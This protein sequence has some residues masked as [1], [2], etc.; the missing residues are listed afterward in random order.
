MNPGE[1]QDWEARKT[2]NAA[3]VP[4]GWKMSR[5][6]VISRTKQEAEFLQGHL[7]L[8]PVFFF[9]KDLFSFI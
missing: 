1:G 9:F 3:E 4:A 2:L 8:K 5:C 7:C 6:G